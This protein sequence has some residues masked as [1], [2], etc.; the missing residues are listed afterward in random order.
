MEQASINSGSA[1]FIPDSDLIEACRRGDQKAQLQIYKLYYKSIYPICLRI[2]ND[3]A[4]AEDIMHESFLT[5][6]ENISTYCG[7]I[8]FSSW[9]NSFIKNDL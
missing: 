9:L 4:V 8:S 6:F 1:S 7:K 5:A 3:P 2:V